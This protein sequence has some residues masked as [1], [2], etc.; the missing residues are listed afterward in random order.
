[1]EQ[2]QDECAE[3]VP[4]Q[5]ECEGLH[6]RDDPCII[7]EKELETVRTTCTSLISW[8]T[9]TWKYPSLQSMSLVILSKCFCRHHEDSGKKSF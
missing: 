2:G 5:R 6:T 4:N 9:V 7:T 8:Y 1:M 3:E